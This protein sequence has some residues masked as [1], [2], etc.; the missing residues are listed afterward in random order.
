DVI[1][2]VQGR[3]AAFEGRVVEVPLW[4]RRA[5]DQLRELPRV[6]LV[7]GTATLGGEVVL[8]PPLEL[9]AGRQRRLACGLA[10]YQVTAHRDEAVA[11]LGPERCDDVGAPRAPIEPCEDGPLDLE[12][13]HQ[14][15]DVRGEGCLLAVTEGLLGEEARRPVPAE[16]RDD[17]AIA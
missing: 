13:V 8:I 14:R 7:A 10:A 11:A 4:R 3:R 2:I 6:T 16:V 12:R 9:G 5:P 1:R 15:R 17:H